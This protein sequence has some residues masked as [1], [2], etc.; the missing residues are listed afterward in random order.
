MRLTGNIVGDLSLFPFLGILDVSNNSMSGVLSNTLC[1]MKIITA[2]AV[3]NNHF[4]GLPNCSFQGYIGTGLNAAFNDITS[5]PS[6]LWR[7]ST[8][9][10][11]LN[12]SNCRITH[13]GIPFPEFSPQ[14]LY[15]S[16][17]EVLDLNNNPLYMEWDVL[18]LSF[19]LFQQLSSVYLQNCS[20]RKNL[21]KTRTYYDLPPLWQSLNVAKNPEL[22]G[23]FSVRI[24]GAIVYLNVAFTQ[25]TVDIQLSGGGPSVYLDVSN[26]DISN[27]DDCLNSKIFTLGLSVLKM[28]NLSC[29][30]RCGV[31]NDAVDDQS[32][33]DYFKPLDLYCPTRRTMSGGQIIADM[34]F[35]GLR[36]CGCASERK[37]W[38][39]V[40]CTNCI[41]HVICDPNVSNTT[42]RLEPGY[43][44][45]DPIT[46]NLSRPSNYT[47]ATIHLCN[48]LDICDASSPTGEMVC[49]HGRQ[50]GSFLCSKCETDYF[51]SGQDCVYCEPWYTIAVP[52]ALVLLFVIGA[53]LLWK[54]AAITDDT[55]A[56]LSIGMFAMQV[57]GALEM[58]SP[59]GDASGFSKALG[60]PREILNFQPWAIECVIT[61]VDF[62]TKFY[63]QLLFPLLILLCGLVAYV[64][65]LRDSQRQLKTMLVSVLDLLYLPLAGSILS[66]YN[67]VSVYDSYS[68]LSSVPYITCEN[69]RY[70]QGVG[71]LGV[72]IYILGFPC[73]LTFT[74]YHMRDQAPQAEVHYLQFLLSPFKTRSDDAQQQSFEY[75]WAMPGLFLMR[76]LGIVALLSLLELHSGIMP[77][78]IGILIWG[79]E[80][81]ILGFRPYLNPV[82]TVTE[83]VLI[84]ICEALYLVRIFQSSKAG[85][86]GFETTLVDAGLVFEILA[87]GGALLVLQIWL[88]KLLWNQYLICRRREPAP[89]GAWHVPLPEDDE[90]AALLE[91]ENHRVPILEEGQRALREEEVQR[92]PLEEEDQRAPLL[93]E[94]DQRVRLVEVPP[95]G[96]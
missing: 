18:A 28:D 80:M 39:G 19:L 9:L 16:H 67:C 68:F 57:L 92:V 95:V 1:D 50:Q 25:L 89:G 69:A 13:T 36:G 74:L 88:V 94:E 83:S 86:Y 84:S 66:V 51:M 21:T 75:G 7:N 3:N 44:A 47:T 34:D 91:Q 15:E 23:S 71:A 87:Y 49:G 12:L 82:D 76:K 56:Q 32:T 20:L 70:M 38:N 29:V 54:K 73:F 10:S 33:W 2:I 35:L 6:L 5:I 55:S 30:R 65:R 64:S 90:H 61:S 43:W 31:G 62:H 14:N 8:S 63:G 41:D 72:M 22:K 37:W 48:R 17:L 42:H 40:N 53:C 11:L 27:C 77:L 60:F 96:E 26:R 93:G 85:F 45:I 78:M 4:S 46:F 24:F 79:C 58:Y 81:A 59:V 52:I